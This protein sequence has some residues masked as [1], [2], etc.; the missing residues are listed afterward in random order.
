MSSPM[1]K[2]R[3]VMGNRRAKALIADSHALHA[4]GR[5]E[6]GVAACRRAVAMQPDRAWFRDELAQA[7]TRR[8]DYFFH[9][10]LAAELVQ[11]GAL[12]E[13]VE[14][15][16]EAA[17]LGGETSALQLGIGHALTTL[18]DYAGAAQHLR[19]STDLLVA[20]RCPEHAAKHGEAGEPRGPDF[21]IIGATKCGTTSLYE[22]L[23][24]HPRV[25][26]AAW[27]EIEYFRF[28]E[29]GLDWYLAHF[30]RIPP[31]ERFLSGEASTCYIGMPEV[32]HR[33][34]AAFPSARLIALLRDPVDKAISHF[35]HDRKLGVESRSLE[36]AIGEELDMLEQLRSPWAD[37]GDYWRTQRGYVWLGLY[38]AFVD[39]WLTVYRPDDLLLIPS[40]D[41]YAKPAET[42]AA[43]HRHLGLEAFDSTDFP[44]HLKG[45]YE[46]KPNDA[47]RE[48]LA[49]FFEPHTA[50]LQ[51]LLGRDLP[52]RRPA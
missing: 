21:V 8:H 26:P 50:R 1:Q 6:E 2:L 7:L 34:R 51:E 24:R 33:L 43:V 44:V 5:W 36:Q 41:L 19:R 35:H 10:A 22:Y 52:W 20:E 17:R 27:K 13:A 25:L 40:E 48:R 15:W 12:A 28:P 49:R 23:L 14:H 11:R 4:A 39:D 42:V 38:A 32:K 18:G 31:G 16:R 29:R 37:A 45:T 9:P 30:P 47:L 46:R 3:R